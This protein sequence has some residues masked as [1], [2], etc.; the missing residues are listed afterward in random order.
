MWSFTF[1]A[2]LKG[3]F[4]LFLVTDAFL[5]LHPSSSLMP[6][7]VIWGDWDSVDQM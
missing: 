7:I 2:H 4:V 3:D 6:G 5:N 1:E